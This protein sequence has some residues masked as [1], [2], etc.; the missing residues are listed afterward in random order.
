MAR[1]DELSPGGHISVA[2]EA[3]AEVPVMQKGLEHLLGDWK[4]SEGLCAAA[5]RC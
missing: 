5:H 2:L 3:T 1:D 4:W